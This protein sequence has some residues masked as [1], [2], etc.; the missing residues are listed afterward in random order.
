MPSARDVAVTFHADFS[1]ARTMKLRSKVET[2][3]F[4]QVL[5]RCRILRIELRDVK[6]VR[7][8][9][10]RDPVLVGDGHQPLDQVLQLADVPRPPVRATGSRSVESAMPWMFLRNLTL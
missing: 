9:F 6:L 8:V 4:Q 10:V 5:G 3:S 2:R 1:S 7:Q